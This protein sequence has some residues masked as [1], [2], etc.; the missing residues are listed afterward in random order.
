MVTDR[1]TG[2]TV[3]ELGEEMDADGTSDF[4][5]LIEDYH[6]ATAQTFLT[7]WAVTPERS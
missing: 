1:R 3:C 7:R 4:A 2:R 6:T 5:R